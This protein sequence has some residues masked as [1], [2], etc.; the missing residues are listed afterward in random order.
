LLKPFRALRAPRDLAPK[1]A[2][3]P[4]DVV[5]R[6]E[7]LAY[8]AGNAQCFFHVSRPEIDLPAD[9][10]EHDAAVYAKGSENLAA[11]R[12]N[13][14]L[15][16]DAQPAFYL[17]RQSLGAHAQ[18]G[19]VGLA[20]VAD[21]D[22]E[23]IRKHEHTRPDKEDDRTKHIYALGANDES[24]FLTYRADAGIDALVNEA[25][26][27][28]PEIDFVADD[29]VRHT[30]WLASTQ[31]SA[32]LEA[33]IARIAMLYIADGHHRCAAASRA[34]KLYERERRGPGGHEYFLATVFPHDQVQILDYNR[35]V[36]DLNG[37]SSTQFLER[38]TRDFEV[39]PAQQKKP[40]RPHQFG[41][42]LD[43]RWYR[44][45]ARAGS[46]ANDTLG[47]LDVTILHEN[48]LRAVLGIGDVRTDAR[49]QFIGGVRGVA[50]LERLV[51][52]G[53]FRAAFALFP[54][55]LE[56][57]MAVADAGGIM[58]PKSTWFEPKLRSG[59]L[60][61]AFGD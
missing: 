38:L 42:Y 9:C 10:D 4:Y 33:R 28:T 7:A 5:N 48:I 47:A 26:D 36:K 8:A 53:Q 25:I 14:W 27:A 34:A 45:D 32:E 6:E 44:L 3:L 46:F 56:Q 16:R 43:S 21:Y 24:V 22:S 58:P 50:E 37:L 54:T 61:H 30:I 1:I 35:V 60:L 51:D 11:F 49:V 17:Y 2:C 12:S 41:L 18:V 19:V 20:R 29:G 40:T 15:R 52:A 31:T 55:Q 59:L 13:G 23:R 57:L 39:T